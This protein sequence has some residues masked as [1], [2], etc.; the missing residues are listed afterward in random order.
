MRHSADRAT[1]AETLTFVLRYCRSRGSTDAAA[2]AA[3]DAGDGAD[4]GADVGAGAC[5]GGRNFSASE[6]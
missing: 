5:A 4:P 3:A 1:C 6:W 2:D